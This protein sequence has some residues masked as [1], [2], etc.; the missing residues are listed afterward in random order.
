[1]DIL[2]RTNKLEF[3][4]VDDFRDKFDNLTVY[5][6]FSSFKCERVPYL[7]DFLANYNGSI[8]PYII[9]DN[10][11]NI[12]VGYFTLI[13]TCMF[14][15][16]YE[17]SNPEHIHEKDVKGIIPCVEIQHF[18]V[19]DSYL[20]ILKTNKYINKGIGQYIFNNYISDLIIALSTQINFKYVILHSIN[21]P[22]VINSY[23]DMGFETVEDDANNIIPLLSD[24]IALHYDNAG[25]CK[26]M[27]KALEYFI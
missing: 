5:K 11:Y 17:K 21:H 25:D 12:I 4:Y 22:N 2:D 7:Q 14:S 3:D 6:M 9:W 16:A 20:K 18:A 27:F 1:M 23:R 10:E 8:K 24:I 13:T 15:S 19:N 26:L